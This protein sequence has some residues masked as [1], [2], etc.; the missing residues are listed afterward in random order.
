MVNSRI[1]CIA[2]V[3]LEID[4]DSVERLCEQHV[5]N[6]W[7]EEKPLFAGKAW[8]GRNSQNK[9]AQA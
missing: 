2:N 4:T 9:S 8:K 1:K 3:L 7:R 6:S 5:L